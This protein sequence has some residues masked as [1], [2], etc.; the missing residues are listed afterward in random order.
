[1]KK[2]DLETAVGFFLLI[3]I[4]SLA[5]ISVKLGQLE[6]L[7]SKGYAVYAEFDQAG[8]IKTGA[9][10]EI[11]G[12]SIG[13][14]THV[15]LDKYQAVLTLEINKGVKLQDDSIASIKTKGLIG[16]K[17]IQVTPG[18]SDKYIVAGGIIRDTE[19][20]IDIESLISKYVFGKV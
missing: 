3:G 11:A 2:I 19:S 14:V 13:K 18:A 10:V 12:V 1:M 4:F 17:F 8:G 15:G 16:E 9:S 20:A 5:Y 6:V 7:S